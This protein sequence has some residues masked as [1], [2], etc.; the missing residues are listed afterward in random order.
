M[1][2]VVLRLARQGDAARLNRALA[3]L[4]AD[5]GD[6]HRATDAEVAAAG[7]GRAPVF[8]A[9]LAEAAVDVVGVALY[10]PCF[11]TVRG[12]AVAYLSDLWVAEALRGSGIGRKLL[13]EAGRDAAATWS[14][15]RLKL[16]VYQTMSQT[17]RFYEALGFEP[18]TH[19]TELHLDLEDAPSAAE[20]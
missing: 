11:S 3:R 2:E 6:T 8:R 9:I 16:N 13:A 12:G 19:Q 1:T 20:T 7:W 17:R 15:R 14:A 10:S 18:A 4:S 5:L